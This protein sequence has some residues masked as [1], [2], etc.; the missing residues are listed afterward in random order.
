M[1]GQFEENKEFRQEALKER[2]MENHQGQICCCRN[3]P[4]PS[5]LPGACLVL[6]SFG[7]GLRG[8]GLFIP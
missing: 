8:E 5:S 3:P 4:H 7:L 6:P 2:G 1:W